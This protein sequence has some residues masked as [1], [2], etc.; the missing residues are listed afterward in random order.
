MKLITGKKLICPQKERAVR[1][2]G[3]LSIVISGCSNN[4]LADLEQ[5]VQQM[6]SRPAKAISPLPE[7]KPYKTFTYQAADLRNPF[8]PTVVELPSGSAHPDQNRDRDILEKYPL[9]S[10]IMVG[11]LR[12]GEAI[13]AIIHAPDG[14]LYRVKKG[15]YLGQNYGKIIHISEEKIEIIEI[16]PGGQGGWLERQTMLALA[17]QSQEEGQ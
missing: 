7:I 12:Q 9:D 10:L 15:N 8:T 17:G 5:Y 3:I 6:K 4:G 1:L 13:W 11:T 2:L 16:V 14:I